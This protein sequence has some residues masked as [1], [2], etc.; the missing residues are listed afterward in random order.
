MK[1][2]RKNTTPAPVQHANF[3]MENVNFL[4]RK[5]AIEQNQ[6]CFQL[7]VNKDQTVLDAA[8]N[9]DIPLDYKCKK[10]TCGKCKVRVVYGRLSLHPANQLEEKK[11]A[12]LLQTG[13]RLACQARAK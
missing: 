2:D 6:S 13:F 3:E 8:L 1:Y 12:H 11:L 4:Q 10:G 9:Q 5:I 7:N